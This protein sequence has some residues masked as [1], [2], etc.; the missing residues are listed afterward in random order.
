MLTVA[1][2]TLRIA[3]QVLPSASATCAT[4][5]GL[6][7]GPGLG[8]RRWRL[9]RVCHGQLRG[10]SRSQALA[11]ASSRALLLE[12]ECGQYAANAAAVG[13]RRAQLAVVAL[14]DPLEAPI[15]SALIG[16]VRLSGS[17]RVAL[18]LF[19]AN[20]PVPV[21]VPVPV[22]DPFAASVPISG[23]VPC[24]VSVSVQISVPISEPVPLPVSVVLSGLQLGA[25]RT[26]PFSSVAVWLLVALSSHCWFVVVV[27]VVV[28]L[29]T[30]LTSTHQLAVF[31][32]AA[33]VALAVA[34]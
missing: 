26:W 21:P 2:D 19:L 8:G 12:C 33:G 23:S 18:G 34:C 4:P 32:P 5:L 20:L 7:L 30:Y 27:V 28:P 10:T 15:L 24:A 13:F 29:E 6:R 22:S 25:L 9:V 3:V 17:F 1:A 16:R 14:L 11:S 31:G